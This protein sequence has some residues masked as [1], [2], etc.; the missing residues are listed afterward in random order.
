[1]FP[2]VADKRPTGVLAYRF[3]GTGRLELAGDN[4]RKIADAY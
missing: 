3:T 2:D 4:V 1:M